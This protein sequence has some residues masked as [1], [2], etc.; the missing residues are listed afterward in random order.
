MRWRASRGFTLI[1]LLV[2]IAIIAI[3]AAILFPVFVGVT[4]RARKSSCDSNMRQIA[5]ALQHYL[6]DHGAFPDQS[7]AGFA[8]TGGPVSAGVGSEWIRGFSHRCRTDS[9]DFAAGLAKTLW[10]YLNNLGVYKCPSELRKRPPTAPTWLPYHVGSSY[11]YKHVICWIANV[12]RHPVK[13]SDAKRASKCTLLYEEAWH[14]TRVP[15]LWNGD[16]GATDPFKPTSAIFLDCH[17]G[18]IEVPLFQVYGYDGN[19]FFYCST[20]RSKYDVGH[21]RTFVDGGRDIY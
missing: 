10:P 21:N 1:E 12:N 5:M 7:S 2:V 17:V 11:Y 4:R 20:S 8:Y 3:L 16:P 13:P 18:R 9:G 14:G 6:S 19:W 15:F